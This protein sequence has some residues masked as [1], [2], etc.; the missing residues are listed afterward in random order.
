MT[1]I[2]KAQFF[3]LGLHHQM[4]KSLAWSIYCFSMTQGEPKEKLTPYILEDKWVF[5]DLEGEITEI[6][7]G[8]VKQPLFVKRERFSYLKGAF[9]GAVEDG[10]SAFSTVLWHHIVIVYP[11][12][13]RIPFEPKGRTLEDVEKITSSNLVDWVDDDKDVPEGKFSV[14]QHLAYT[15]A[16]GSL[17]AGLAQLV[18]TTTTEKSMV[19]DPKIKERKKELLE[20]NKDRLHDPAVISS[21]KNELIAMDKAWIKGD[22]AEDFLLSKKS[23]DQVRVKMK[24]MHGEESAFTDG[25]SVKLISSSL[26]EGWDL[27]S[28]V[29]Y[30]NSIRQAS[31]MRGSETALGGELSQFL[32]RIFQNHIVTDLK[33]C[34]TNRTLLRTIPVWSTGFYVGLNIME[35]KNLVTLTNENIGQYA[36]KKVAMRSPQFCRELGNGYCHACIGEVNAKYPEALG[37]QAL[38]IGHIILYIFMK[39][40]HGSALKTAAW[41]FETDLY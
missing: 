38:D 14:K 7:D 30:V 18:T 1:P 36:G 9:V 2:T 23:Y 11:F 35:G 12:G 16:V 25:T 4:Y 40:A 19:T 20:Q 10:E 28:M 32:I 17:L 8:D 22:P 6:T 39:K 13:S 41:D 26:E 3:L 29:D 15:E 31:F 34:G 5:K 24:I 33:D 37:G 21:I 27:D